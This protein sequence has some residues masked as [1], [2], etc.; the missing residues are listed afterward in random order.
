MKLYDEFIKQ[1][2]E[3]LASSLIIDKKADW[4]IVNDRS[5]I[6]KSYM[7][8][9]LGGG[10]NTGLG[11]T[12]ITDNNNLISEDKICLLGPDICNIKSDTSY[13]RI[14]LVKIKNNLNLEGEN[15]YDTIRNLEHVR[16]HIY[17]KG[18]MT[19]ASS[20]MNR[21]TVRVSREAVVNGLDFAQIGTI[22]IN[23]YH[24]NPIV[25]AVHIYYITD[26]NFDFTKIKTI[27]NKCEATTKAIDHILKNIQMDCNSCHLQPI[28]DEVDGLKELH[29]GSVS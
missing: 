24:K 14:A 26:N 3:L 2:S 11:I 15:L 17:P 13:A 10:Q 22:T 25:E 5:M 21:E 1:I 29:F 16:Y 23:E 7:A 12:V 20:T 9:E 28:C 19:R 4:P 8:F 18:F 6:L 27:S